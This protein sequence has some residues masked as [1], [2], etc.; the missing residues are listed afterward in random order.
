MSAINP[1]VLKTILGCAAR[2][3]IYQPGESLFWDDPHI[4]KGMLEAHLN[5]DND[6]ASRKHTTIDREVEHLLSSGIL[7]AG[8]RLLDLGCG[9]GLYSRRLAGRGLKVTGVDVSKRSLDYATAHSREEGLDIEFRRI[10]FFDIDYSGEFDAVLQTHG[11]LNVFSDKKRDELLGILHRALKP[12]GRLVFDITTRELRM[13]SGLKNGWYVS[14]GGFWRPDRHI[15]LEQGF[16][17]PEESV[18]LDQY[19]VIDS[20]SVKIYNNW[21]HDYD[22]DT[23]RQVLHQAGFKVIHAWNDLSG[24]VYEAGGDWIAIVAEKGTLKAADNPGTDYKTLVKQSYD[25]L[26]VRYEEM[27]RVEPS[28]VLNPL[29]ERLH[30][31]DSIL[32]IGCGAGVPVARTL[33]NRF[34]VTGVDISE[35]MIKRAR[36]N[37]PGAEFNNGDIMEA[38]FP[39]SSFNAVTAF[40][41]IFHLPREEHPELLRRIYRW[42]KPGGYLLAT[43]SYCNDAPYTED[44]FGVTMYWSNYGLDEYKRLLA[45][46]GFNI[47]EVSA[48]GAGYRDPELSPEEKHPLVLARKE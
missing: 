15:V 3:P 42:L 18:W 45:E 21:F 22:L 12:G 17:Y 13:K 4:S 19:I 9:P 30:D 14:N 25:T 11:E 6:L 35:G 33:A 39:E 26:A 27:R 37:V 28:P 7:K 38:E 8:D 32:D 20:E 46:S 47:L 24:S 34:R 16:D 10:N 36:A 2:P 40:Y 1:N 29:I 44:Y 5:P 31:G 41:S 23:I 48:V 43:L